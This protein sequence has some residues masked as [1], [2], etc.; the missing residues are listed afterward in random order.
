MP[1]PVDFNDL[2]YFAKVIEHGGY[3]AAERAL[4]IP[5]SRLSRRMLE[6][7]TRL[8]ICL[9][10]RSTRRLLLTE[11]GELFLKH[12]RAMLAEAQFGIEA[13]TQLQTSPHGTVRVSCPVNA[14]RVL[15]AP[16]LPEFLK[17]YTQVRVEVLATNREIDLYEDSVDV[18]L[19]IQPMID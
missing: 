12:C 11:A 17:N 5:K 14:S 3:S 8:G 2:F 6:L 15:L 4:G 16:V 1:D 19:R 7:E 10:Q 18:A 9:L 13:A